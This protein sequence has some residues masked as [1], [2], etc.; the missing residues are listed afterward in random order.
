M[1]TSTVFHRLNRVRALLARGHRSNEQ[2]DCRAGVTF[3]GL[4]SS[5]LLE[6]VPMWSEDLKNAPTTSPRGNRAPAEAGGQI[7]LHPGWQ[8]MI[9][10]CRDMGYGEIACIKI[11]DGVPVSA[12]VVTRKIRWY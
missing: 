9:Q 10:F 8:A 4:A 12:E 11:Y 2:T 5:H 1:P 3:A 6:V 7:R